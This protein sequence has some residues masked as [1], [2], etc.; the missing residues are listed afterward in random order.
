MP[1]RM[2]DEPLLSLVSYGRRGPGQ[3]DRLTPA[4]IQQITRTVGCAPE[5]MVKVL[6]KGASTVKGVRGHLD[7][8]G[9]EGDVELEADDGEKSRSKDAGADL[10][11]RPGGHREHQLVDQLWRRPAA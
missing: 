3:M 6:P 8:I 4:Q 5:V 11:R 9:R 2:I 7:Y 1:N 10:R